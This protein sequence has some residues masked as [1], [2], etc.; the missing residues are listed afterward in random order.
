MAYNYVATQMIMVLDEPKE[1]IAEVGV[2]LAFTFDIMN[3]KPARKTDAPV[4]PVIQIHQPK[5]RNKIINNTYR[6]GDNLKGDDYVFEKEMKVEA[7]YASD[8]LGHIYDVENNMIYRKVQEEIMQLLESNENLREMLNDTKKKKFNRE[9]VNCIFKLIYSHFERNTSA[10]Q[11][12]NLIYI[13]DNVAN[14]SGL[15]YTSLYDLLDGEYKQMLL[16]ELDKS[17]GILKTSGKA[18]RL[19]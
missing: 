1:V 18:N 7:G 8:N 15:K 4:E 5:K 11:F 2:Q 6:R 9:K 16:I 13:F 19:F 14:L 10:K 12:S 17:F 3:I